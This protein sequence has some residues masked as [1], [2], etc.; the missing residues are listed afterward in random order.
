MNYDINYK[1]GVY[2]INGAVDNTTDH[3][4]VTSK[5]FINRLI[6]PFGIVPTDVK[7]VT[8]SD[9]DE[10]KV[11]TFTL[12]TSYGTLVEYLKAI[13]ENSGA[14]YRKSE[15]YLEFT[16]KD[17]EITS[18]KYSIESVGYLL[19]GHTSYDMHLNVETLTDFT[20]SDS[21]Q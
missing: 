12:E 19:Y 1:D 11:Y 2:K 3:N 5:A 4:D 8:V 6:D 18:I 21:P 16:V 13:F 20:E 10:G 15:L 17:D 9:T 7:D 14:I